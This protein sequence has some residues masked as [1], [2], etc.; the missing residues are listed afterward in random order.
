MNG[1][2]LLFA[3]SVIIFLLAFSVERCLSADIEFISKTY[4]QFFEDTGDNTHAPFYEYVEI[5]TRD[6]LKNKVSFYSGG[7]IRYDLRTKSE[8]DRKLDELSYAFVRYTP[9]GDRSLFFDVGRHLV[10]AGLASELVDGISA[11][12]EITPR[13]GFALYGGLPVETDFDGRG[14]DLLYGGRIFQRIE[15]KAELG[16][17]FLREDDESSAFREEM[18]IDLW[19]RPLKKVEISGRSSYNNLTDGWM[20]HTYTLRFFLLDTLTFTGVFSHTDYDDAF[21]SST[22]SV[23]SPEFLGKGETLMKGGASG[24]YR[25][26][27]TWA[28]VFDFLDYEYESMGSAAYFGLGVTGN[29]GISNKA[30]VSLHRMDGESERLAYNEYRGYAR[31]RFGSITASFDAVLHHYDRPFNN[32]S[33]TYSVN[34]T[35]EYRISSSLSAGLSLT[36]AKDP[37]FTHDT[38]ALV[39]LAYRARSK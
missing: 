19:L 30:G 27:R 38:K 34:A 28:F 12:W 36:H 1:M 11:R 6:L 3:S 23:F 25:I 10:F 21:S 4:L 32:L 39:K 13:T 33:N 8:E 20:E 5:N 14:G 18:G 17:S 22:L 31:K 7:W 16:L 9:G 29:F 26:G 35:A 37:D 15:R 24:E 2:R